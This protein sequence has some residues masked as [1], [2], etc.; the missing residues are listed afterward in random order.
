[1]PRRHQTHR[2]YIAPTWE[3]EWEL[4]AA[5]YCDWC[6]FAAAPDVAEAL[7]S[8]NYGKITRA[9]STT[10]TTEGALSLDNHYVKVEIDQITDEDAE[11]EPIKWIGVIIDTYQ[12]RHGE[13]AE[14]AGNQKFACR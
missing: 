13:E 4:Q 9:N 1:M 2:V 3:D 14:F 11:A 5:I 7:L 12:E 6:K 8:Y 10:Q